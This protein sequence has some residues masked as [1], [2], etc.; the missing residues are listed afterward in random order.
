MIDH[1]LWVVL[2]YTSTEPSFDVSLQFTWDK[3]G[4]DGRKKPRGWRGSTTAFYASLISP[5]HLPTIG[6]VDGGHVQ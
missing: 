2:I 4:Q 6:W 3:R 5:P 1:R